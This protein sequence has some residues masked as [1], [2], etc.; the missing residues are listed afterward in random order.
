MVWG[1]GCCRGETTDLRLVRSIDIDSETDL[2]RLL[3][4]FPTYWGRFWVFPTP[5]FSGTPTLSIPFPIP[6]CVCREGVQQP[7]RA[8]VFL[9]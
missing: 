8:T 6:L 1:R 5:L 4:D 7:T 2:L 9:L 3:R